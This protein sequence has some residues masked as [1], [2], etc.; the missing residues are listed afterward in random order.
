[1]D[2]SHAIRNQS[3]IKKNSKVLREF[4]SFAYYTVQFLHDLALILLD[5][6]AYE[7]YTFSFFLLIYIKINSRNISIDEL[8]CGD[9][10]TWLF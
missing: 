2:Y 4:L 7:L 10:T 1:M 8:E 5:L 9:E 3:I 6:R